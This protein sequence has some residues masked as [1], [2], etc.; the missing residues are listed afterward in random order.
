MKQLIPVLKEIEITLRGGMTLTCEIWEKMSTYT[1]WENR[2]IQDFI[3]R[4]NLAIK[5]E[6]LNFVYRHFEK[7]SNKEEIKERKFDLLIATT[8]R[9]ENDTVLTDVYNQLVVPD[10]VSWTTID[11]WGYNIVD[12]RNLAVKEACR[13]GCKFLLFVDDDIVAPKN[14]LMKLYEKITS[15]N[16]TMVVGAEYYKKINPLECAHNSNICAMGF[17]LIAIE[18]VSYKVPFP[19]FHAFGAPDG[20]WSLG[21]DAF[22]TENLNEHCK[23]GVDIVWDMGVLHYDKKWKKMYGKRK[24]DEVYATNWIN[25][26]AH[27]EELRVPEKYPLI[28]V[29]IPTRNE[30][31]IPCC[32]LNKLQVLRG[33]DSRANCVSGLNVDEARNELVHIAIKN[34]SEFILFLDDDIIPP[35]DGL[36][37]MLE[38]MESDVQIGAIAGDYILKGS[39]E[40]SAHLMLNK[41]GM[42]IEL[43]R[44]KTD[45]KVVECNWLMALG[46]CLVRTKCFH[47]IRQPWFKCHSKNTQETGINE[48]AHFTELLLQAGYKAL[49]D[50]TIQ[51]AHIDKEKFKMYA[52]DKMDT[53][54]LTSVVEYVFTTIRKVR[55]DK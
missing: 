10:G 55:C 23:G 26:L 2:I 37:K 50:K 6:D 19:L 18:D 1:D 36:C 52:Y 49:I 41:E 39:P 32:D 40:H 7:L 42:V 30:K 25:D 24:E 51:C 33:Y 34:N 28:N 53:N 47:Q 38:Q 35:A 8:R 46:F 45:K 43:N 48:D 12:A 54:N 3:L 11:I 5:N 27:F 20:Y 15:D 9:T 31:D 22:F 17:T 13:L 21:E 29:S 14:A 4:V 44:L 16:K